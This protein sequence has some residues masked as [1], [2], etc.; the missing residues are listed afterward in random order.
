LHRIEQKYE[1]TPTLLA[2][3]PLYVGKAAVREGRGFGCH[4][5]VMLPHLEEGIEAWMRHSL[6]RDV[7]LAGKLCY[8]PQALA[9]FR[10]STFAA[11]SEK[12]SLHP[13]AA[14][15]Q[16]LLNSVPAVNPLGQIDPL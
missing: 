6:H 15:P 7:A 11:F 12:H 14:R 5:L 3:R 4:A 1:S 16:Q 13:A 8:T 10:V 2:A 9:T